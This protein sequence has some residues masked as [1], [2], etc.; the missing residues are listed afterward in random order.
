M[1]KAEHNGLKPG[2]IITTYYKGFYRLDRIEARFLDKQMLSYSI[3][4]HC[5]VGD[6][7][8]SVFHFT[9]I[10][11]ANCKEVKTKKT[12][13]CDAYHCRL[14]KDFINEQKQELE[15][16]LKALTAFELI[17]RT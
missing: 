5:K 10:A 12:N 3:Y 9:K 16:Q 7:Y 8:S 2:D 15:R 4:N 14:A 17:L 13:S 1:D 6:E 11:D